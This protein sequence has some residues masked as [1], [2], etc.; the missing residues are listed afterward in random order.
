MPC[1]DKL[2]CCD[3]SRQV[4]SRGWGVLYPRGKKDNQAGVK[5]CP[6]R[7]TPQQAPCNIPKQR[8][9]RPLNRRLLEAIL[10]VISWQND[11]AAALLCGVASATHCNY[12]CRSTG[13]RAFRCRC[14]G[15]VCRL[16]HLH[17]D[18][19]PPPFL[20]GA[21]C[22]VETSLSAEQPVLGKG[23]RTPSHACRLSGA[24]VDVHG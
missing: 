17:A 21:T 22:H 14:Y 2:T 7:T 8:I 4:C 16:A 11:A 13:L 3:A 5:S 23:D 10:E 24:C 9:P 1:R 20:R 15:G 19:G 12:C 6:Q 18:I